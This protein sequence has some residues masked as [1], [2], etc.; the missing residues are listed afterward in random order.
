M[1]DALEE[2]FKKLQEAEPLNC[3]Q[4]RH[5]CLCDFCTGKKKFEDNWCSYC[6]DVKLRPDQSWLNMDMCPKCDR[7]W[8]DRWRSEQN[9]RLIGRR[10]KLSR[11]AKRQLNQRWGGKSHWREFYQ[12]RGTILKPVEFPKGNLWP[13]LDVMWDSGLRYLY[14][15]EFL[16]I[17]PDKPDGV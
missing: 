3:A 7:H 17:L 5:L 9:L 2:T 15:R 11:R 1:L 13:E 16:D 12:Q 10:V 8:K 4:G 6:A 14:K